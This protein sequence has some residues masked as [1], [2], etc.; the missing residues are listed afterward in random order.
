MAGGVLSLIFFVFTVMFTY[1]KVQVML[2]K[3][4]VKVISSVQENVFDHDYKF[5]AEKG[6]FV[7]AALV[8]FDGQKGLL[9][10]PQ[11][12]ELAFKNI[13]WGNEE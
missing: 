7:A 2:K 1:S 4:D 11:Y 3:S 12:G 9:E 6:L 5:T 10:E 8:S 13:G